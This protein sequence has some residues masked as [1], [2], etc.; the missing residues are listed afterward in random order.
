[1]AC[2][3]APSRPGGIGVLVE[4]GGGNRSR[5]VG[6]MCVY[7]WMVGRYRGICGQN[8]RKTSDVFLYFRAVP[9]YLFCGYWPG[10]SLFFRSSSV[11]LLP[12]CLLFVAIVVFAAVLRIRK[13][14]TR[15][16]VI[17]FWYNAIYSLVS[18]SIWVH[19]HLSSPVFSLSLVAW[20]H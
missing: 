20:P 1:M 18:S 6:E 7:F 19:H 14:L 17:Q 8:H 10:S 2:A 3:V 4:N 16:M 11:L 13:V 5:F 9:I 12:H 15:L